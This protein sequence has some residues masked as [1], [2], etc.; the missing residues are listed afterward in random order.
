M[1][2]KIKIYANNNVFSHKIKNE[3]EE[4]LINNGFN[5]VESNEDLSIAIGGDGAFLRMVRK[6]NFNSEVKYIGINTGT[7]GFAQEI[8]AD[9]L[10]LFVEKLK[11]NSYKEEKIGVQEIKIYYKDQVD[12]FYALNEIVI[13]DSELNTT[14]LNIKIED[15]EFENFAG[16]GILISTSFGSTAYNLSFGGAIVYNTLHTLQITPIAPLNSK[17]YRNL[18]NSLV[19]PQDKEI[20]LVP[21]KGNL[22]VSIDGE[23]IFYQDVKKIEAS[24]KGKCIKV[25]REKDYNFI[26][27]VNEKLL[28]T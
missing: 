17:S 9:N 23:N 10:D 6:E 18:N 16:D 5:L 2:K 15:Y 20:L 4:K 8:N 25:L 24:V 12:K 27:K 19:I 3:L 7:L 11:N 1:I 13:R 22:I 26:S 14:K 28:N 21:L